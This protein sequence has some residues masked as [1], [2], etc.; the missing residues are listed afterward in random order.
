MRSN[1]VLLEVIDNMKTLYQFL[2]MS[3]KH[4]V[5]VNNHMANLELTMD[6]KGNILC[7]NMNFPEFSPTGYNDRM[8]L[9]TI[10][11]I[12]GQLEKQSPEINSFGSKWEEI[13]AITASNVALNMHRI[14]KL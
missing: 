7:R 6:D 11:A 5:T 8:N 12:V 1:N 4:S 14:G 9:E 10:D 3:E 2:Y 13:K